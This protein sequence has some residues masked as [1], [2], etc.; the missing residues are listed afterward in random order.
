VSSSESAAVCIERFGQTA[1]REW[2]GL[3]DSFRYFEKPP[4][5]VRSKLKQ[6]D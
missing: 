6:E 4:L 5:P 3:V 2:K 1:T